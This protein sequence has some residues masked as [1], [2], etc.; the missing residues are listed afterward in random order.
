VAPVL[1]K[2]TNDVQVCLGVWW[3][4]PSCA[5]CPLLLALCGDDN[6]LQCLHVM[7]LGHP[8]PAPLPALHPLPLPAPLTSAPLPLQQVVLPGGGLWYDNLDGRAIDA[9]QE[10]N[11]NFRWGLRQ[12]QAAYCLLAGCL[13][14][15]PLHQMAC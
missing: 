15:R 1:D 9:A 14:G 4:V 3:R 10:A 5:I 11:R 7:L 2:D 8:A 13:T 12:P 6:C